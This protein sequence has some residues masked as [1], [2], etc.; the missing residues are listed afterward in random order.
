MA[1]GKIGQFFGLFG[2]RNARGREAPVAGSRCERDQTARETPRLCRRG[3]SVTDGPFGRPNK[4]GPPIAKPV[5]TARTAP[6]GRDVFFITNGE[7]SAF[8]DTVGNV[9]VLRLADK[10]NPYGHSVTDVQNHTELS[11]PR[12]EF[13]SRRN[14]RPCQGRWLPRALPACRADITGGKWLESLAGRS[15]PAVTALFR[16]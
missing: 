8:R 10:F 1:A 6:T 13:A 11:S 15:A 9:R 14:S 7:G 12:P 4:I 16:Q 2:F 3:R 5:P